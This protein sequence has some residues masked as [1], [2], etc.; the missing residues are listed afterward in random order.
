[1]STMPEITLEKLG[2]LT[3]RDVQG[4][5]RSRSWQQ[6]RRS[7]HLMVYNRPEPGS[8]DQVLVPMDSTRP[9]FAERMWDAVEKL[10]CFEARALPAIFTDLLNYDADVLRYRVVSPRAERGTLPL[11]QAIDLLTGAKQSLLAAA[12]SVL[13]RAKYHPKLS[14]TEARQLLDACQMNQTEQGSFVVAISC[15]MRALDADEAGL[16]FDDAPFARHATTLLTRALSSLDRAIEEDRVNSVVEQEEPIVSANLCDALL[17]MR[18][19]QDDGILEF[20]PSWASS[21]PISP[22]ESPPAS[23][24]FSGDEFEAI[25]EV[26][27][28]LRPMEGSKPKAWIAFVD[29]LKGSETDSGMREGEV[30]FTIVD[31]DELVRAKA[32][33]TAEQYQL[34]YELHNPVRPLFVTG[35]LSP[36]P[37]RVAADPDH[38]TASC[39]ADGGWRLAARGRHARQRARREKKDNAVRRTCRSQSGSAPLHRARP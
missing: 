15:P 31:D 17:K 28:Q 10:A 23:I 5:V 6:F 7:G 26:Y 16:L 21:T 24:T 25:E 19:T 20:R 12:H 36:W 14:R 9:D 30:I 3:P 35:Q 22:E 2:R 1:M 29:E 4:Y 38:R 27:R 37:A 18:P 34:A 13:V 11:I 8:L 32:N 39:A 33:L